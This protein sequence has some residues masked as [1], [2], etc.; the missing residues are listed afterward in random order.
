VTKEYPGHTA[1]HQISFEVLKGSV[2]AFLGP[3]GAGK[4]TTMKILTG[5]IPATSGTVEV[6][7]KVGFLPEN[8]PLYPSMKVRDYLKFVFEIQTLKK[9]I[10]EKVDEVISRCG[11]AAVADRMIGNLSKGYRQKVGIAQALVFNPEI[12][13]LDEPTVGLDP[14][15]IAEIRELILSLKKDHTIL[16]STHQLYEAEMISSHLTIINQGRV[17]TTGTLSEVK[18]SIQTT[19][20]VKIKCL[21]WVTDISNEIESKFQFKMIENQEKNGLR[22]I[23]LSGSNPKDQ[24]AELLSFLAQS[25][26]GLCEFQELKPDLEEVFKQITQKGIQL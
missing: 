13:I 16:L 8:P 7:A 12:I 23:K 2:H 6:N 14:Q 10:P 20:L 1:L 15:A 11:L 4:S 17:L 5:L 19:Q 24:R 3:N 25:K 21:E 22:E 26:L 9:K 18:R